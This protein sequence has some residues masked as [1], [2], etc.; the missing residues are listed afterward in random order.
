M[1][2]E[3]DLRLIQARWIL[4]L[5]PSEELPELAAGLLSRGV[6]SRSLVEL[7]GS[8]SQASGMRDVFNEA[9]D[10]LGCRTME[11]TEALRVYAM[12]VSTSIL[13]GETRPLEGAKSI[14]RATLL[15]GAHGWHELD[16][17]IYAA[18]EAEDRPEDRELFER[19]ILEEAKK[20]ASSDL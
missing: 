4:G 12:A 3:T 20:W 10:E 18:S 7:A 2:F 6:E 9:L 15:V 14:W 5:I 1:I 13:D 8:P 17:F 19:A 16:P 11:P